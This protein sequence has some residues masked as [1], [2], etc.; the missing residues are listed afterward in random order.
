[1]MF[2][3]GGM[4]VWGFAFMTASTVLFWAVIILGIIALV[5]YLSRTADHGRS[6]DSTS[7]AERLLADRFA[8]GEID[9]EEYQRRLQVL[10]ERARGR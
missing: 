7:S 9:E 10:G 2:G 8:R 3:D 6:Q 1:M 5:R 4:G